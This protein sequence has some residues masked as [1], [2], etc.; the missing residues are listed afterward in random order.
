MTQAELNRAV[1]RATGESIRE[2]ARR[3]FVPLTRVP[4]ER[5]PLIVDWDQLEVER[6]TPLFDQQV[7]EPAA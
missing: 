4:V 2:I 1:A 5:E 7:A 3:G 6:R